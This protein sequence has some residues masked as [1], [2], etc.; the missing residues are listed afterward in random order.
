MDYY[1]ALAEPPSMFT[2]VPE[3]YEAASET[4]KVITFAA[5]SVF[6][7]RPSGI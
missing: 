3:T 4:R 5:S 6:P 1:K 2:A 7:I